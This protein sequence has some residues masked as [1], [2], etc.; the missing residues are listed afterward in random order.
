MNEDILQEE[1]NTIKHSRK[2]LNKYITDTP[3]HN[4]E[5]EMIIGLMVRLDEVLKSYNWESDE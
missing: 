2:R 1:L 4:N 3:L 5:R